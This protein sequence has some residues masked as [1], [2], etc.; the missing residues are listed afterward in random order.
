MSTAEQISDLVQVLR[1]TMVVPAD[2]RLWGI[3]E[4]A[5]YSGYSSSNVQ[6]NIICLPSFPK[7]IKVDGRAQPRWPAGEVMDWFESRR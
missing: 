7:R 6:Q 1:A 4:I 3:A 2:R 5:D